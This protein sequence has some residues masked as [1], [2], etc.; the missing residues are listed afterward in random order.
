MRTDMKNGGAQH[1]Q[2]AFCRGRYSRD[3]SLPLVSEQ[4]FQECG[5]GKE[6]GEYQ[7]EPG[8]PTL[9]ASAFGG[10]AAYVLGGCFASRSTTCTLM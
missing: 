9:H 8:L 2:G 5:R 10:M 6:V 3:R 4:L 1:V 7:S